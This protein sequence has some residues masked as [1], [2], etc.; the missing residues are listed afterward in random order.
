M[1]CIVN[2]T[3]IY[4]GGTVAGNHVVE[5]EWCAVVDMYGSTVKVGGRRTVFIA[6]GMVSDNRI[7]DDRKRRC[8]IQIGIDGRSSFYFVDDAAGSFY[9]VVD[10]SIID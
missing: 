5:N 9:P 8:C 3:G 7:V 1:P 4:R 2:I 6:R 10:K